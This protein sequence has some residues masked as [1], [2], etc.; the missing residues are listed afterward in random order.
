MAIIHPL[1]KKNAESLP[2]GI[3][4]PLSMNENINISNSNKEDTNQSQILKSWH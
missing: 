2:D 4:E 1:R 3:V